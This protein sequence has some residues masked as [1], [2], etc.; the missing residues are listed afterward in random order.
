MDFEDR[1]PVHQIALEVDGDSEVHRPS[2]P[3]DPVSALIIFSPLVVCR[4]ERVVAFS[5]VTCL[6]AIRRRL[7]SGCVCTT[8]N[9]D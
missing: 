3:I 5:L 2:A 7:E 6:P 1:S 8:C 4:I 9:T